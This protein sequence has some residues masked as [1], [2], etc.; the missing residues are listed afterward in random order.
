M[1]EQL[2]FSAVKNTNPM[3]NSPKI[4]DN[5]V[6]GKLLQQNTYFAKHPKSIGIV[7]HSDNFESNSNPLRQHTKKNKRHS[8]F[9]FLL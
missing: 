9:L 4:H 5:F 3:T 6:H 2:E 1:I 7:L 8:P